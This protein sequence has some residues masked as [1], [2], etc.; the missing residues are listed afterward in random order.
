MITVKSA[1]A[2]HRLKHLLKHVNQN[3]TSSLSW[4]LK[5]QASD[6]QGVIPV[7]VFSYSGQGFKGQ[8]VQ[9]VDHW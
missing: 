9:Q 3:E 2:R 6:S 7:Q 8:D 1:G 4:V 5:V